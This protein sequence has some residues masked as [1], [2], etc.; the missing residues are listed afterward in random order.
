MAP[1]KFKRPSSIL[2]R[3]RRSKDLAAT[4]DSGLGSVT[5][6]SDSSATT[7]TIAPPID[8]TDPLPPPVVSTQETQQKLGLFLLTPRLPADQVDQS[9][10]DI[11]AIHGINGGA[12]KTW[13]HESGA[14]WLR[15]FLPKDINGGARVFSFGYDSEV[16]LTK[17]RATLDDFA[18]SLLNKLKLERQGK[19]RIF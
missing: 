11:V 12:F 15:D 8:T 13:T 19:V 16:A 17:S 5:P 2:D 6:P 3:L 9:L 7:A 14:L 18:W 1:K 4:S 10:L